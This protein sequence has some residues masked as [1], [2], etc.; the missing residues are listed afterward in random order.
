VERDK[1]DIILQE[2]YEDRKFN[3]ETGLPTRTGLD[4]LGLKDIA[5]DLEARGKL[6]G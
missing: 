6:G 2:Y 1:F 3:P 4:R 5:D